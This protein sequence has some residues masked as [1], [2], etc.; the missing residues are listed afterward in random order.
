MSF[1]SAT[2]GALFA[3]AIAF[4]CGAAHAQIVKHEDLIK[5]DPVDLG[6]QLSDE[7]RALIFD[8][9]E[10]LDDQTLAL[11]DI[12]KGTQVPRNANL[13]DFPESIFKDVPQLQGFRYFTSENRVVIVD[14]DTVLQIVTRPD[15]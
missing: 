14:H 2:R 1:V 6:L 3:V 15:Q 11:G 4:A 7:D 12:E 9:I 10:F 13:R 5:E 8:R